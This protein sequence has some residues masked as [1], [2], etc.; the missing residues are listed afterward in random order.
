MIINRNSKCLVIVAHPDDETLW[1]GGLILLNPQ[2][3]WIVITICRK[4]DTNRAPKFF[5]ALSKLNATGFM[6][7]LDD[8][9]EQNPL[10]IKD[11]QETIT[12]LLPCNNF[13]LVVTHSESGEYTRHLRHEETAKAVSDLCH[14]YEIHTN[15]FW[16]FAYEDGRGDYLPKAIDKADLLIELNDKIWQKKCNI[17]TEIYGFDKNSFE[18]K[19][20]PRKEAFWHIKI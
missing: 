8:E 19:T 17:I 6:G 11:V 10:P 2:A 7:D 18:A 5:K 13:D 15:Q 4:S 16:K 3:K 14:N 12:E 20:I 9:P 1:A